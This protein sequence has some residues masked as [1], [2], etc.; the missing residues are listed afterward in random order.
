MQKDMRPRPTTATPTNSKEAERLQDALIEGLPTIKRFAVQKLS[1]AVIQHFTQNALLQQDNTKFRNSNK[2]TKQRRKG[3]QSRI[4]TQARF[5][6]IK[7][8]NELEQHKRGSSGR[9]ES[10]QRRS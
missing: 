9:L 6:T 2:I 10:E 7:I 4:K 5:L 8:L 3:D 1:K